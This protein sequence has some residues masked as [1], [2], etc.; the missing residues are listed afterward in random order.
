MSLREVAADIISIAQHASPERSGQRL[1]ALIR[2][3]T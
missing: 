2:S 1:F 3:R